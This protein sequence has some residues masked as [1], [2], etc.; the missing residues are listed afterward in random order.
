MDRP[1]CT[2]EIHSVRDAR[3]AQFI[4]GVRNGRT[5]AGRA[6]RAVVCAQVEQPSVTEITNPC[7]EPASTVAEITKSCFEP[8][9]MVSK[10]DPKPSRFDCAR[11]VAEQAIRAGEGQAA[12]K[13]TGID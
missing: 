8:A 9:S 4:G 11:N 3:F 12:G 5:V 7:F 6:G 13:R 10:L 1:A 2:R